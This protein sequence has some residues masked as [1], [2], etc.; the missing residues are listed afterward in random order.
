MPAG[1][2]RR[3][4]LPRSPRSAARRADHQLTA[5]GHVVDRC[6]GPQDRRRRL[7]HQ[8]VRDGRAP[9]AARGAAAAARRC[10][11]LTP[12]VTSSGRS[13]VDFRRAEVTRA[14]LPLE[15]SANEF[16]LLQVLHRASRRGAEPQGAAGRGLGLSRDAETR[17]VDVHV[18]WLR[19]KIEPTRDRRSPSS[20]CTG[21]ATS[22]SASHARRRTKSWDGSAPLRDCGSPYPTA[23]R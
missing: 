2:Q 6:V 16:Q 18:A 14:G 8:A 4:R 9:R 3:R 22:S 20:P 12:A 23:A 5:R 11:R 13:R 1:P 10:R 17:T 21:S 7:R 19:Q 15:L